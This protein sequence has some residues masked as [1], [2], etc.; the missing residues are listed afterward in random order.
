MSAIKYTNTTASANTNTHDVVNQ[1]IG[2]CW[3]V[4]ACPGR[5]MTEIFDSLSLEVVNICPNTPGKM[6]LLFNKEKLNHI[7]NGSGFKSLKTLIKVSSHWFLI[8][9]PPLK[10]VSTHM[11]YVRSCQGSRYRSPFISYQGLKL[12]SINHR[13]QLWQIQLYPT[14][15]S[16]SCQTLKFCQCEIQSS[17]LSSD[18][19]C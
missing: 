7:C 9:Q 11:S 8:V 15:R 6:Q 5:Q 18:P 4:S 17:A 14:S 12:L 13:R 19:S 16:C 3:H 1:E 10:K 2:Q